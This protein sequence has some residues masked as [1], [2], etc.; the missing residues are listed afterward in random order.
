[1][2]VTQLAKRLEI[3]PPSV[4]DLEKNE[5]RGVITL[6]TLERAARALDC[7]LVYA[8]VPRT[9][10]ESMTVERAEAVARQQLRA[11]AHSM[12]LEKQSVDPD[13]EAEQLKRLVRKLLEQR[14][15]DLWQ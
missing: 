9:S 7:S 13:D 6:A 1:M 5:A 8:V 15:R 11:T 12:A 10:L 4:V 2:S 14:S 3:S